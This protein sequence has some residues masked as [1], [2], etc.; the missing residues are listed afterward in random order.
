MEKNKVK[1][2]KITAAWRAV[3]GGWHEISSL[4]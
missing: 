1:I 4:A 2:A 3:E